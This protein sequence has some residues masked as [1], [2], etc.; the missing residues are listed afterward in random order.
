MWW[1]DIPIHC[2]RILSIQLINT[3]ISSHIYLFCLCMRKFQLYNTLLS[4]IATIIYIRTTFEV[5]VVYLIYST[6]LI[7]WL[8]EALTIP[9]TLIV[10]QLF[11]KFSVRYYRY[12]VKIIVLAFDVL[13]EKCVKKQLKYSNCISIRKDHCILH[14]RSRR[15]LWRGIHS[16]SGPW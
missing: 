6:T 11:V 12:K 9:Q 4:T 1:F 16:W 2:E 13:V 5:Y 15:R 3:S 7:H 14:V 8:F 10:Y